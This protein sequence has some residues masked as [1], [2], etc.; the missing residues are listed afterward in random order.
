METIGQIIKARRAE[1]GLTLAEAHDATKIT[2]QNLAAIEE[3][4]FD[5]F[6]NRVYARAFLRDYSN[7]LGLDSADLLQRYEADWG[8]PVPEPVR[9]RG[10]KAVGVT[11]GTIVVAGILAGGGFLYSKYMP[12]PK[13]IARPTATVEEKPTKPAP[14]PAAVKPET[15]PAPAP[16]STATPVPPV[17]TAPA[18]PADTTKPAATAPNVPKDKVLI[19]MRASRGASWITV[20]VDGRIEASRTLEAGQTASFT[21]NNTISIVLGNAGMVDVTANGK[22]IGT[23]GK[24]GAVV[25][26]VFAKPA[27]GTP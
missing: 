5:A 13:Q 18:K 21:G 10:S 15:S 24:T 1:R 6:P 12:M 25:K 22:D 3:N 16:V 9:K 7:Y 26:K 2:M 20:K 19:T 27:A 4:R 17:T 11:I 23:I 8:S 14:T